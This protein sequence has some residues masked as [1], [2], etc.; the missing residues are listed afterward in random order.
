MYAVPHRIETARLIIRRYERADAEALATV[1]PRNL[2]HLSRYMEWTAFEPQSVEQ[3][4]E[5]IADVAAKADAGEDFTMG[6]FLTDGTFVGGTGFH[7]RTDPDRLAIGYWIDAEHEGHGLV[8]EASTALAM[9]ALE[10]AGAGVV[11]ISHAPSNLRSA[12]VPQRLG[13]ERQDASGE[14]CF[15]SGGKEPSVTWFAT[16]ANLACEPFASAPRPRAF[17]VHGDEIPWPE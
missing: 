1:V 7:V 9:V 11:D 15:D 8:T 13:F 16:R 5:W 3:R 17:D 4:R 6:I 12:R 10:I 14:E 2:D